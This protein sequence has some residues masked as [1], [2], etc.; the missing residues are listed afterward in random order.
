[1]THR[2]T[3]LALNGTI[4]LM[5]AGSAWMLFHCHQRSVI[6]RRAM[7]ELAVCQQLADRIQSLRTSPRQAVLKKQSV[8]R[9]SLCIQ[10]AAE[11]AELPDSDILRITPR[12]GRRV[13]KSPHVEQPVDVTIRKLTLG[14]LSR[15][16]EELQA[17]AGG[18]QPT[19]IRL[20]APRSKPSETENE[21]WSCE[22]VLTYLVFSPE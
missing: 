7:E 22:L 11:A 10:Q 17:G 1:M 20:T 16:L 9:I 15:F 21:L 18:L 12:Q 2:K 8:Q 13:G 19:S 14:Q 5:A 4:M 3:E 6:A